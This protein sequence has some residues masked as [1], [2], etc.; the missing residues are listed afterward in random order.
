MNKK[1]SYNIN[2]A[3]INANE[4]VFKAAHVILESFKVLVRDEQYEAVRNDLLNEGFKILDE[5]KSSQRMLLTRCKKLSTENEALKMLYSGVTDER[6]DQ[7][8]NRKHLKRLLDENFGL[9]KQLNE[10]R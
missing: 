9:K 6:D 5:L 7:D 3:Q 10:T 4:H 1:E 2:L 8:T